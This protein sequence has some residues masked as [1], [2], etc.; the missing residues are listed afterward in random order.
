MKKKIFTSGL[1]AVPNKFISVTWEFWESISSRDFS[2]NLL[3]LYKLICFNDF[4]SDL[5]W[6]SIRLEQSDKSIESIDGKLIISFSIFEL[7]HSLIVTSE[8]LDKCKLF[9]NCKHR[10]AF[11]KKLRKR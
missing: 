11:Y 1:N 2:D 5:H 3:H 8:I 7:T 4:I 6:T 10:S 9:V